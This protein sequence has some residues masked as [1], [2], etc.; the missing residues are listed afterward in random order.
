MWR[1]CSPE[2]MIW[3][4]GGQAGNRADHW[5]DCRGE[6]KLKQRQRVNTAGGESGG[7]PKA[8][9]QTGE[10][11][12]EVLVYKPSCWLN[13][14]QA[15]WWKLRLWG[16][17]LGY[18]PHRQENRQLSLSDFSFSSFVWTRRRDYTWSKESW[19]MFHHKARLWSS[20]SWWKDKNLFL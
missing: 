6:S 13:E 2:G 8:A 5:A 14:A 19:E 16:R 10:D 4:A 1:S 12:K 11:W 18:S 20:D 7:T 9:G 3:Q 17:I 15:R